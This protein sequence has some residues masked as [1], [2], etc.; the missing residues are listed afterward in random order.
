MKHLVG[1]VISVL[2]LQV[3][4]CGQRAEVPLPKRSEFASR[5]AG[6][7]PPA[8]TVDERNENEL[9]VRREPPVRMFP[10]VAL[11]VSLLR[12][13]ARYEEFVERNGIT[14]SYQI[15]LR[16]TA[17]LDPAEY[18]RQKA[19]NDQI[20]VTKSTQISRRE[21]F[22]DDVMRSS[23]ARYR[24]LPQYY[25]DSHSVYVQT[26]VGPYD[27]VHPRSVAEECDSVRERLDT[28]FSQYSPEAYRKKVFYG[29]W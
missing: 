27:C 6:V 28:L 15:R 21:F 26:T 5:I 9:I 13:R 12:D 17:K 1:F 4:S 24:E 25:D 29:L 11:D 8:W 19:L 14:G 23:D 7:L 18:I 16:R 2:V 20:T 22:E 10:C 3:L